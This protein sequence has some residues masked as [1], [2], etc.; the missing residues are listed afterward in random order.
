MRERSL[1][2]GEHSKARISR[3]CHWAGVGQIENEAC[4]ASVNVMLWL[5]P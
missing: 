4:C 3:G 1:G 5:M 2:A